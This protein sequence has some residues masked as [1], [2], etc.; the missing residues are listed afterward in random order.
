M[1]VQEHLVGSVYR[2]TVINSELVGFFR[3]DPPAITGDG[4]KTISELIRGKN[5][6]RNERVSPV[7]INAELTGFIGRQGYTLES[8]PPNGQ[9]INLL[10]KTGRTYGGYTKEMLPEVH[11]K[12]HAIFK[13]AG[14]IANS[15]VIGFDL[16]IGDPTADPDA[17]RWGI[18]EC[19]SLPFIDLH[20]FAL[21]GEPI[22]LAKNVWDLWNAN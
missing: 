3:N 17:Q 18:I 13:K 19:N 5:I 15:P 12:M 2:A 11:P 1:V 22:N 16:I 6:N 7:E 9:V 4:L 20:Y 8:V 14:E 21:E 10:A